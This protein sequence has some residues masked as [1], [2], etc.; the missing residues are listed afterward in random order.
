MTGRQRVDKFVKMP[1]PSP[2]ILPL[3][4]EVVL[5]AQEAFAEV[6]SVVHASGWVCIARAFKLCM[7]TLFA[8]CHPFMF[9]L[10]AWMLL[11]LKRGESVKNRRGAGVRT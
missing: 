4:K 1:F 5:Q 9:L 3:F 10:V 2:L 8:E 7:V 6:L 11:A